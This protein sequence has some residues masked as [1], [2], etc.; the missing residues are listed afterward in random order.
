LHLACRALRSGECSLALAG[1][2]NLVLAPETSVILSRAG[3]LSPTGRCRT[4]DAGA[5]G[6]VRAEGCGMVV[7]KTVVGGR[8]PTAIRSWR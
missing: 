2:V 4:F 3:M 7:L 8:W 1:G 6:F 5:D